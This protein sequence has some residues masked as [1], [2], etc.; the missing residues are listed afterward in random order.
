MLKLIK[1]KSITLKDHFL[2]RNKILIKR[3]L[4]G[5]GDILM[6]RMMFED[7]KTQ[8]PHLEFS[9]AVPHEFIGMARNHPY[10]ETLEVNSINKDATND[11]KFGAV[12]DLNVACDKQE[13]KSLTT[14]RS[15][16][17]ASYCGIKLTNHNMHLS[18]DTNAIEETK[19]KLKEKS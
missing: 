12:Y 18:L 4:G 9:W 14:H 5:H 13:I 16:I 6:Q 1:K 3:R 2:R 15:D 17:W 19:T 8:F 10:V 11:E 7:F